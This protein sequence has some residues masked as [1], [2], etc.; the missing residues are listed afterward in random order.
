MQFKILLVTY[1]L[2]AFIPTQTYGMYTLQCFFKRAALV[3]IYAKYLFNVKNIV[4]NPA[5]FAVI[6]YSK[7]IIV[8]R[9][10]QRYKGCDNLRTA[11]L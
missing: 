1:E 5:F 8:V 6:I 9:E 10:Y 4:N 3:Q 11:E 7:F 2:T